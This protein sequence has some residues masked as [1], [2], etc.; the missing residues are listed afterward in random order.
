MKNKSNTIDSVT[1]SLPIS[2][3]EGIRSLFKTA[4][5]M[6]AGYPTVEEYLNVIQCR[7]QDVNRYCEIY[8]Q[9]LQQIHSLSSNTR[10]SGN[11]GNDEQVNDKQECCY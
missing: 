9:R 11:Q 7:F 5:V 8:R 4:N 2:V 1:Q 3:R 6:D 10:G